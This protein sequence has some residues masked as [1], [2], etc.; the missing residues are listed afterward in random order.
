MKQMYNYNISKTMHRAKYGL[1]PTSLCNLFEQNLENNNFISPKLRIKR[2]EKSI[3]HAGPN[4]W[5]S[6]PNEIIME[7]DFKKFQSMLK[8]F[9][10]ETI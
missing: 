5:N 10:I 9:I 2:T 7:S 6:I 1:L 8:K 4:I 3:F